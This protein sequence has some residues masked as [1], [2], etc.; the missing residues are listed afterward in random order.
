MV[1]KIIFL[2]FTAALFLGGFFYW[3]LGATGEKEKV[4]VINRGDSIVS[5]ARRL[6]E[7]G[8]IKN[9]WA[10]LICLKFLGKE[11]K[12]QAGSFR[13]GGKDNLWGVIN[14]LQKGMLDLWVTLLEG[15]R[16]E[17]VARELNLKL[18]YNEEEFLAVTQGK[19]GYLFPDSYLFPR[20]ASLEKVISIIENNFE[21]KWKLLR[22]EGSVL[23]LTQNQVLIFASLV[24]REARIEED[25]ALVAG[26][27]IK[28]WENNWPLQVDATV[29]YAK[30]SLEC[31]ANSQCDWWPLVDKN[32]LKINSPYNTYINSNLPLAPICNPSFSSL[33]S[34]LKPEESDYWF[35]L[36]D[37]TG[38]IHF[39]KTLEEHQRNIDKYLKTYILD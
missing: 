14:K 22:E 32:D 29:Q 37:K 15:W 6:E 21:K 17:E 25:R 31:R 38:R 18:G 11:D 26:V 28:R 30:A 1:K 3:S 13:L 36:S 10:F 39:A 35:Y 12:I 24:E 19:E 33:R 2:I 7:Q 9:K 8:L 27:L 23:S 4:F 20:E 16:R 5:I 34:V